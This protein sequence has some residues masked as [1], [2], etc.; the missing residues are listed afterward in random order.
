MLP[1]QH[2]EGSSSSMEFSTFCQVSS[3][4]FPKALWL[5]FSFVSKGRIYLRSGVEKPRRQ[6]LG[7]RFSPSTPVASTT[8]V[9]I[10]RRTWELSDSRNRLWR[11][12][13]IQ[14]VQEGE[15]TWAWALGAPGFNSG[16]S[17]L[18][19]AGTLASHLTAPNFGSSTAKWG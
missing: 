4:G 1:W 10:N 12:Q 17:C 6:S 14:E 2:F 7:F 3:N 19:A 8:G 15:G 9:P 18:Q 13:G 16:L 11:H 5:L